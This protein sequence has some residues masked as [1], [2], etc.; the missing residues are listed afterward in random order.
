MRRRSA[1]AGE[2]EHKIRGQTS[3]IRMVTE[4]HWLA[5][6]IGQMSVTNRSDQFYRYTM[7]F[8]ERANVVPDVG[9]RKDLF[10]LPR[11][12]ARQ[13]VSKAHVPKV[14]DLAPEFPRRL[15]RMSQVAGPVR[16]G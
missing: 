14:A 2:G 1:T 8:R 11:G 10:P 7:R 16:Q 9:R 6:A 15:T 13:Y 4:R 12:R 5:A 3:D